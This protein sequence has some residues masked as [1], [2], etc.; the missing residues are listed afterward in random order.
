VL[1]DECCEPS[2]F[3]VL[4]MMPTR[5]PRG[6]ER[7]RR[8]EES[9]GEERRGEERRGEQRR[10]EERRGEQSRATKSVDFH[11][12]RGCVHEGIPHPW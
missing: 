1:M 7:E 9:R 5:E 3:H 4:H 12:Q 6:L 10:G 2:S 8:A 11:W